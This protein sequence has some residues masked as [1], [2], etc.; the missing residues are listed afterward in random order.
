MKINRKK[1]AIY[2]TITG[3]LLKAIQIVFPFLIRTVFIRNIGVDYLGLN[4]LFTSILQVLNLAELG[5]STAL[6]F[7]MYKP[8]AEEDSE[9]I[10]KLINFYK[11][12]YRKI[13]WVI[14]GIGI[15]ILPFVPKLIHG[16]V[17]SDINIY[18]IYLMNLAATVLSY[19]LFAYRNSLFAAHQ[20]VDITSVITIVI[21]FLKYIIQI[22]SLII[23]KNYYIYLTVEI[24]YSIV[25]NI[26]T[27]IY[28]RKV[29]P[30]YN[31]RG[32]LSAEEKR[33][34]GKKIRDLFTAKV[35][36]VINNS[37]DSIVIS[38]FLGLTLLAEYQNY[39]YIVSTVM[40]IFTIFFTA[41]T[42]G[43][44]NKLIL[45]PKNENKK[46][47]YNLNYLIF[48]ALNFC[49]SSLICLFQPFMELW[50][51][52]DLMMEF[53]MVILFVIYLYAEEAPRTMIVFKDAAGMWREDRFRPL[54][55]AGV[56]LL[57]NIILVNYIG[58]YGILI[59]TIVSMLFI[60]FPWLV[61]NIDKTLFKI[62]IGKFLNRI[63]KYTVVIVVDCV[64][65]YIISSRLV[66]NSFITTIVIRGLICLIIPNLIFT[67]AFLKTEENKYL[68]EVF[69]SLVSK[70]KR[71]VS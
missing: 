15:L 67:L 29:F 21:S 42:A 68:E 53:G 22:A 3:I 43:I 44:G 31:A 71:R 37:A 20:R 39:Y 26:V 12:I 16:S 57:L 11:N 62:D 6:V 19:W 17:P 34:I 33:E 38:S 48:F 28:S 40:A 4:S 7:S 61:K 27:A 64:I 1:N 13:G 30:Y 50:V 66:F 2:G 9:K 60:G 54:T 32:E 10:C 69:C 5:V 8:I 52:K 47:F 55:V 18:I 70:V 35:G 24:A 59:S 56:N 51:G 25:L 23:F 36:T 14:L 46:L 65:T 58:L 49:C 63:F 45:Q 41:C